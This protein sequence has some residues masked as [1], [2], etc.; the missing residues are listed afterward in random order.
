M[1]YTP[2]DLAAQWGR[3]LGTGLAEGYAGYQNTID[4]RRK[5]ALEQATAARK[6]LGHHDERSRALVAEVQR[7]SALLGLDGS[8]PDL[9]TKP[10]PAM[11]LG[12][13]PS[14]L[15]RDLTPTPPPA[16][17]AL[18]LSPLKP[19]PGPPVQRL[20]MTPM[21]DTKGVLGQRLNP[22]P[23]DV[24]EAS[25]RPLDPAPLPPRGP[26]MVDWDNPET[27][28]KLDA[29]IGYSAPPP[30]YEQFDPKHDTYAVDQT[31]GK[32]T[33][34]AKGEQ[35]PIELNQNTVLYDPRTKRVVAR[36]PEYHAPPGVT[37]FVNAD[38]TV[39]YVPKVPGATGVMPSTAA[40]GQRYARQDA[41]TWS[42]FLA[43]FKAAFPRL[44]PFI[45]A[46]G[47]QKGGHAANGYHPMGMA[48]DLGLN[49]LN[50]TPD[51]EN[52]VRQFWAERNVHIRDERRRSGPN[53]TGPHY[54][55]EPASGV[56]LVSPSKA[57]DIAKR[58]KPQTEA[59]KAKDR[60]AITDG[61]RSEYTAQH[62]PRPK[63]AMS[64]APTPQETEAIARWDAGLNRLVRQRL[65]GAPAAPGTPN[66]SNEGQPKAGEP[67]AATKAI[68]DWARQQA[69]QK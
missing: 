57:K 37:P 13:Q 18:G 33:L 63:P 24:R 27:T 67:D 10:G 56:E 26:A 31:T 36:G 54:H 9:P 41:Q 48:I 68:I 2:I 42:G 38:G 43:D 30:K 44:A 46:A 7:L 64:M 21:G 3:D 69:G 16:P 32:R 45:T 47:V 22:A 5:G 4:Y 40:S 58:E 25:M 52:G 39:T 50:M 1:P 53:W 51:E 66:I 6:T 19:P 65:Q 59:Q 17:T 23:Y 28:R 20:G 61:A 34:V 12:A 11:A 62:G 35:A 60:K 29:V 14:P 49:G 15:S 55:F 8:M